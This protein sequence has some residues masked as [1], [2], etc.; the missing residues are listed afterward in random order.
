[1]DPPPPAAAGAKGRESAKSPD[2]AAPAADGSDAPSADGRGAPSADGRGAHSLPWPAPPRSAAGDAVRPHRHPGG[3]LGARPG[4][5]PA[6]GKRGTAGLGLHRPPQEPRPGSNGPVTGAAVWF[7]PLRSQPS[8][9]AAPTLRGIRCFSENPSLESPSRIRAPFSEKL[10]WL[11]EEGGVLCEVTRWKMLA[12]RF[13]F[14][15]YTS[16]ACRTAS[17]SRERRSCVSFSGRSS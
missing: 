1:M 16:D 9:S 17:C 6:P 11:S 3:V 2:R 14:G 8:S 10:V 12:P 4:P 7:R 13:T 15:R 5:G